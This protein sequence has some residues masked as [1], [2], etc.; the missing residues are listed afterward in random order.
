MK[1]SKQMNLQSM[2]THAA[3]HPSRLFF[4]VLGI[5]GSATS[6]IVPKDFIPYQPVGPVVGDFVD[7]TSFPPKVV[8]NFLG[9]CAN[10][11]IANLDGCI[12]SSFANLRVASD[13]DDTFTCTSCKKPP[14]ITDAHIEASA[15]EAL[16]VCAALGETTSM[17]QVDEL[18]QQYKD[19]ASSTCWDSLRNDD[20]HL[21]IETTWM[22]ICANTDLP[23]P[24]PVDGMNMFSIESVHH[25]SILTCMLD[26]VFEADHRIFGLPL[27]LDESPESCFAPGYANITS[28][29]TSVIGPKAAKR[30]LGTSPT[31]DDGDDIPPTPPLMSMDYTGND[32]AMFI[33]EFCD[34]LESLSSDVGRGCLLD[35]CESGPTSTPSK[36]P[37]SAPSPLHPTSASHAPFFPSTTSSSPV[38]TGPKDPVSAPVLAPS[39]SPSLS[40]FPSTNEVQAFISVELFLTTTLNVTL[41]DVPSGDRGSFIDVIEMAIESIVIG[42]STATAHLASGHSRMRRLTFGDSLVLEVKVL[43]IRDCSYVDCA[44]YGRRVVDGIQ[45]TITAKVSDGSLV[46]SMHAIATTKTV[47]ILRDCRDSKRQ[48]SERY[49]HS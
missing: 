36:T 33:G 48:I 5:C 35:L 22:K 28:I 18:T 38:V 1:S 43:A 9:A 47:A 42:R 3:L 25:R 8:L 11:T 4:V 34:F 20:A 40:Q 17:S 24:I 45:E 32:A 23:Y 31:N 16:T 39:S 2:L 44:A 41:D 46:T 12:V 27:A 7:I 19:I 30:C 37:P 14:N 13:L 15:L 49:R 10:V 29:C 21:S 26:N 6:E